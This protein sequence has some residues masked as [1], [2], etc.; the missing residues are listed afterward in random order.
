VG[1]VQRLLWRLVAWLIISADPLPSYEDL[2]A[3]NAALRTVVADLTVRVEQAL[4]RIADLEARLKLSSANSSKP[5][6]SDGLAKPAPKSLRPKSGRGPGRPKGQDGVTLERLAD[7][8]VVIRHVPAT[9]AGCG[10]SLAEAIEVDMTWRQV[11]DVPAVKPQVAE[12]QLV[13]LACRPVSG[14][15]RRGVHLRPG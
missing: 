1:L 3:E 7:P 10:T 8:D 6:S 9:C 2:V 4:G 12:H 14:A 5:P 11:V 15:C 13:T